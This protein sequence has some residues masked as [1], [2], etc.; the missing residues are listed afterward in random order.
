[1]YSPRYNSYI[2]SI[3]LRLHAEHII[4]NSNYSMNIDK[5]QGGRETVEP[6][7]K[8]LEA[9]VRAGSLEPEAAGAAVLWLVYNNNEGSLT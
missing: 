9:G 2:P 6:E 3:C 5:I 4:K 1:M 8:T 7:K